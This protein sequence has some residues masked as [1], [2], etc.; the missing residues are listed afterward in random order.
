LLAVAVQQPPSH[1]V[2]SHFAVLLATQTALSLD[3]ERSPGSRHRAAPGSP[4]PCNVTRRFIPPCADSP[5]EFLATSSLP[6]RLAGSDF[7]G[8][9]GSLQRHPRASPIWAARPR[10]PGSTRRFSQPLS[11]FLASASS[12]A[13]FHAA[14]VPGALPSEPSPR[15]DRQPLSG[16][17][18]P[19]RS[20]TGVPCVPQPRRLRRSF[21]TRPRPCAVA[22]I[23]SGL[24]SSFRAPRGSPSRSPRT[25]AHGPSFPP[26][27]PASK[28]S[29]PCES[30]PRRPPKS[31]R[32]A[33][34]LLGFFPSRVPRRASDPRPARAPKSPRTTDARGRPCAT[35]RT[36]SP[37]SQV[38]P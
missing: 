29:S 12:T 25:T 35:G 9:L 11:G 2:G 33:A 20:S 7:P 14:T 4:V 38:E 3:L 27:S 18:A 1:G 16:P 30:V 31:T 23:P 24:G 28:P 8:V 37:P 10:P 26:A 22:W 21:T 17:P 36:S 6:D 34:A 5:S 32:A 13:L 15:R 19:L